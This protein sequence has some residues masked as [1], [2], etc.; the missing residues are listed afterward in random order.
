MKMVALIIIFNHKYEHNFPLLRKI[1]SER[2]S[3]IYF[4]CPF[5]E[6]TDKDV[7]SIYESS[8]YFQGYVYQAHD[9][10]MNLDVDLFL[11][12]G[13]DLLLDPDINERNIYEKLNLEHE[14][15]DLYIGSIYSLGGV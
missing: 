9:F 15:R 14:K 2:F 11:F 4:I 8:Y 6:G 7:I 12:I 13:D 3:R 5:Y 1:Y 10:L